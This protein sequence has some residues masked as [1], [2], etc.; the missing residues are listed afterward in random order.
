MN[1]TQKQ[2]TFCQGYIECGNASEAYRRAYNAARMKPE[3]VNRT[4]KELLDNPKISARL[5]EIRAPV[6]E[7]SRLTLEKHLNTLENLRNEARDLGQMSAA[8]NAEVSRGKAAGLYVTRQEI[9]GKDGG[10]GSV[11]K[12]PGW[13]LNL[14]SEQELIVLEWLIMKAMEVDLNAPEYERLREDVQALLNFE[15]Y[16]EAGTNAK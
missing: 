2:E 14:L 10:P 16:Q 6:L 3:T 12:T 9:T 11:E 8:I 1:L 4:A 5:D 7:A 13:N 15:V